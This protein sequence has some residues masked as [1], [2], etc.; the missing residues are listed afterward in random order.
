MRPPPA[1]ARARHRRAIFVG[2]L[3]MHTTAT[4]GRDDSKRWPRP[5]TGW[6]IEYIA[7]TDHSQALA[8]ANGL[9]ERRALEHAA[10]VR[11]LNG[12]FDGLTLLAGI[13]CDI[14]P[15]GR[16]DLADDCLAQLD[17]VVA[18]VHSHFSQDASADDRPAPA[19]DR[20]PAGSTCSATPPDACSCSATPS[21]STWTRSSTAA[22]R[23]GVAMEINCQVDRLDL[24]ESHAR[25]ARERGVRLVISTDAHSV[26]ALG[27]LR[28]GVQIARRA[29]V[30]PA[31]VLNTRDTRD[32]ARG[33]CAVPRGRDVAKHE[34]RVHLVEI[35]EGRTAGPTGSA[36][37][38]SPDLLRDDDQ[39]DDSITIWRTPSSCLKS[40]P[41]EEERERA[42][43]YMEGLAEMQREW[44]PR[45]PRKR[46][47]PDANRPVGWGKAGLTGPTSPR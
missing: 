5:R 34:T 4:D 3:H 2:D 36:G 11:A 9:D 28:W 32:D 1:P 30:A 38:D 25:L 16:L 47:V 12:R 37:R 19:S 20:V 22:A 43:V 40:L 18:S 24:N 42:S 31:E 33:C 39:A 6:A 26:T 7:I 23:H 13:E 35:A 44:A 46:A 14:L 10:R 8:M 21:A 41:G 45:P 27:N 15:D 29:W 17:I